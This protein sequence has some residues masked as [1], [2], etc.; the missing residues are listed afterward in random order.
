MKFTPKREIRA[1]RRELKGLA[2]KGTDSPREKSAKV[3]GTLLKES[4][5]LEK[6]YFAKRFVQKERNSA[7]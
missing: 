3:P 7:K 6:E 2:Q 1:E 4:C 5:L